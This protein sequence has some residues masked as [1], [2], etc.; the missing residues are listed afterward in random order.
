MQSNASLPIHRYS[1][2]NVCQTTI[3]FEPTLF[4]KDKCLEIKICNFD[5][6]DF[7]I[8]N[9]YKEPYIAF[10]YSKMK[11]LRIAEMKPSCSE[12]SSTLFL[13]NH[14]GLTKSFE[15]IC[16]NSKDLICISECY[17]SLVSA[18]NNKVI[19]KHLT[20]VN[21]GFFSTKISKHVS[22]CHQK[23]VL[24]L[25]P[26]QTTSSNLTFEEFCLIRALVK[27]GFDFFLWK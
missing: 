25:I 5:N 10:N 23:T 17:Q 4:F 11:S 1:N 8:F 3:H 6:K 2:N 12:T 18:N 27:P 26:K 13:K 16:N 15:A 24:Q 20:F 19:G 7:K 9:D 14:Q 22:F 21:D